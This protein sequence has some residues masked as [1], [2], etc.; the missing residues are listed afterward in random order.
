MEQL[1]RQ[2]FFVK[3]IREFRK[4][5]KAKR[6]KRGQPK[7]KTKNKKQ[8]KQ[9]LL[10]PA[11]VWKRG[12]PCHTLISTWYIR[13]YYWYVRD[14]YDY[15]TD[16]YVIYTWYISVCDWH[17]S[18]H[19]GQPYHTLML[20]LNSGPFINF[21]LHNHSVIYKILIFFFRVCQ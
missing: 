8:G 19:I 17:T 5:K 9:G 6:T 2:F 12:Q 7:Q 3:K 1:L 10:V 16:I 14:V 20:L 18:I 4:I 15:I 21:L 13:V 11:A